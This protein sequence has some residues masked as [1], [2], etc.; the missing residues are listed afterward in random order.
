MQITS[1]H[2]REFGGLSDVTLSF[3]DGLNLILGNNES[4]KST[5]VAFIRFM[6]YGLPKRVAGE[7]LSDADR[8]FSWQ[9]GVAD[10][11]MS[12]ISGGSPYRI[13][14]RETDGGTRKTLQIIDESTGKALPKSAT[15]ETVFLHVPLSVFDSTA[16]IRQLRSG[17]LSGEDLSGAIENMLLSGDES[18]SVDR[19]LTALEKAR[20]TL[21]HKNGKGGEIYTIEQELLTLRAQLSEIRTHDENLRRAEK[22]CA[23]AEETLRRLEA[24]RDRLE[25]ELK[26]IQAARTLAQFDALRR[27]EEEISAE[28]ARLA[29]ERA[30]YSAANAPNETTCCALENAA[31]EIEADRREALRLDGDLRAA[32]NAEQGDPARTET[33]EQIR[34]NGGAEAVTESIRTAHAQKNR[35]KHFPI[36]W[37]ALAAVCVLAAVLLPI[38][39]EAPLLAL[40]ALLAVPALLLAFTAK[41]K[42]KTAEDAL[43]KLLSPYGV[44]PEDPDPV[45]AFSVVAA[46]A[47]RAEERTQRY[48][49]N[50][51][52]AAA[53]CDRASKNHGARIT[54]V[55]ERFL[56]L[57]PPAAEI[58]PSLLRAVAA[59]LRT[60]HNDYL[61]KEET[62]TQ[63]KRNLNTRALA[64]AEYDEAAL[65]RESA[66]VPAGMTEP[67]TPE[68][69]TA[70][71]TRLASLR[72]ELENAKN[73][74]FEAAQNLTALR[75]TVTSPET[76]ERKIAEKCAEQKRLE[77]KLAAILCAAQALTDARTAIREGVSPRLRQSANETLL[78]L[79]RQKYSTLAV[80]ENFALSMQETAHGQVHPIEAFSGGTRDTV[81]TALRLALCDLLLK[82]SDGEILPLLL[83]EALAQL[84]DTRAFDLLR[85]LL[86]RAETANAQILLF[87]CHT[88]ERALL[89]DEN[90][91]VITLSE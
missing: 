68:A 66:S 10:G 15:P 71:K 57:L 41:K 22:T 72:I 2:I 62:L 47:F 87:T 53:V 21:R 27:E 79:S 86:E 75:S 25:S 24:E 54:A 50:V 78:A 52:K 34:K 38:V 90:V 1:I 88:R 64:L 16:C 65:R 39:T 40:L 89:K 60:Q 4:G 76:V 19:A 9:N 18:T 77:Q 11:S 44:S 33:A 26:Y 49:E 45:R 82:S 36:L 7:A 55:R 42:A 84:D 56:H 17:E 59:S 48:R 29:S 3:S 80:D 14:R 32:E 23:D 20:K 70:K 69:E 31:D 5:V 73:E 13:E 74:H 91:N 63:R 85:L 8:A 67:P 83:D 12:L 43:M 81:Y 58:T 28:D 30:K 61:R 6:F 46:S 35:L 51:E 37:I